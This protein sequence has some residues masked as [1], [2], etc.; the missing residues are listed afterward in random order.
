M[1]MKKRWYGDKAGGGVKTALGVKRNPNR[2][3]RERARAKFGLVGGG[4]SSFDAGV[5][6]PVAKMLSAPA[7][8]K[9]KSPQ[10]WPGKGASAGLGRGESGVGL[11][12]KVDNTKN[13]SSAWDDKHKKRRVEEVRAAA[14]R[15][16]VAVQ[17]YPPSEPKTEKG[18]KLQELLRMKLVTFKL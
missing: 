12:R 3:D 10:H 16:P 15:E 11:K 13:A 9:K 8:S 14:P 7:S 4:G 5:A 17:R 18:Q 2:K 1:S 6:S